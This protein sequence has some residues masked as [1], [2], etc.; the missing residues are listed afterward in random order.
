[1][2][3][4]KDLLEGAIDMHVHALPDALNRS[5][6]CV[7]LIEEGRRRGLKGILIKDHTTVTSDRAFI[8]NKLY[9]DITTYGAIALNYPVGGLNPTAV[10]AAV[11]LGAVQ[12]YMPT[13]CSANH[14]S[15]WGPGAAPLAYPFPSDAKGISLLDE[16]GKLVPEVGQILEIIA[17]SDVIL[18]TGHISVREILP[19]LR[20][21]KELGV[22]KMLVTHA[23][24]KLIGMSISE[25]ME[26]VR[27][28]AHMEHC[29]VVTTKGLA[30]KGMTSIDEIA[31]QIKKIGPESC[32]MSTDFGQTS[33]PSPLEGFEEFIAQMLDLGFTDREVR[34]MVKE[35]PSSVL[36]N[37]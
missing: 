4:A 31:E 27:L 11:K 29:Y 10:D 24:M 19:L 3:G 23:S 13:Y 35:N 37:S 12:V 5:C 21:A 16:E 32:I 36:R 2:S 26:A 6:D 9:P 18:G 17:S 30:S 1:M 20:L 14:V 15:K 22:R 7:D 8:L 33:N 34:R 25:Q 28:G